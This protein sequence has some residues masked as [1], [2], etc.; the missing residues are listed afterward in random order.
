MPHLSLVTQQLTGPWNRGPQPQIDCRHITGD[1]RTSL[2]ALSSSS[3][4]ALWDG[5]GL[6]AQLPSVMVVMVLTL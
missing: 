1:M 2:W 5:A 3:R 4:P 6:R